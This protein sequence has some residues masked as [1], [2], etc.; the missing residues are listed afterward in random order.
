MVNICE[1]KQK[2]NITYPIF[3]E[4]KIIINGDQD[5]KKLVQGV[6]P[7]GRDFKLSFSNFSKDKKY[8]SHNLTILVFSEAERLE[9]FS[10]L[11]G[12]AKY[13]L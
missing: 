4:Y 5:A 13:V 1:T 8:A 11:K 7:G 2:P 12:V 3:W 10:A 9:I 6:I